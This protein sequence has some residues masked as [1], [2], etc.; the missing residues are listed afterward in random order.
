VGILTFYKYIL[1][2]EWSDWKCSR[3]GI[4]GESLLHLLDGDACVAQNFLQGDLICFQLGGGGYTSLMPNV[5][6]QTV[7]FDGFNALFFLL[8]LLFESINVFFF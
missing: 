6:R 2:N 5:G 8:A 4:L 3:I 1:L 7:V